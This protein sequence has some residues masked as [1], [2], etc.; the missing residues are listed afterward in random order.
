M[1]FQRWQ[2]GLD[3]QNGQLCALG[4]ERRRH[5]WQLRH[6][7]QQ[8]LP[9]DTLRNGVLQTMP[10]LVEMLAGWQRHLPKRYSLR[11]GLPPQLVLQRHL[12]LPETS[13]CEPALSRYV[14]ASAQRL[15]PIDPASLALDYRS[16]GEAAQLC[17]T[18]ARREVIAQ[19][20]APF[21]QAGLRPDVFELSSL[22]L[23]QVAMRLPLRHRQL[24]IHPLSDHWLWTLAGEEAMSG[25][26]TEVLTLPQLRA[27]FPQAEEVFCTS[28]LAL[29]ESEVRR[30]KPFALLHYI[31]PPLPVNE[32]A[33]AIALGLALRPEDY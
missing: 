23:T 20:L 16:P 14:T 10:A 29:P 18:A 9:H 7:W 1:A 32:G 3:I 19:W 28:P 25:A 5:G 31:Q 21:K 33:F 2:I 12:P 17:I 11:V 26:A 22:A 8:A 27:T 6:W 4:I 15:F 24:L 30:C 13:L